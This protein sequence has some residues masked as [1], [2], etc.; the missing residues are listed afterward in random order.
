MWVYK[1]LVHGGHVRIRRV[2]I[3]QLVLRVFVVR[4]RLTKLVLHLFSIT[5]AQLVFELTKYGM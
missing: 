1:N 2:W 4:L 5:R 3:D